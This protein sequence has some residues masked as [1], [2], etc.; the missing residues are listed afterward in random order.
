MDRPTIIRARIA[1]ATQMGEP[2]EVIDDLRRDYYASRA[3][4]YVREWLQSDP[5]PT[6]DQRQE[7]AALVLQGG[8]S[9]AA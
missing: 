3:R 8:A 5:S 2:P 1:R 7:L 6:D 4:D 9:A